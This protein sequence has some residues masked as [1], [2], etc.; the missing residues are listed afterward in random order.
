MSSVL[1]NLRYLYN[2]FNTKTTT[3]C[4]KNEKQYKFCMLLGIFECKGLLKH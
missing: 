1:L 3:K 4:F 2:T